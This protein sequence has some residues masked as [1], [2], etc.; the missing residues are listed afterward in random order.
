MT[1]IAAFLGFAFLVD[2]PDR[3]VNKKYWGFVNSEE[4]KFVIRRID[5][6]RSDAGDEPWNFRKW[7]ASAKDWKI[8]TFAMIFLWV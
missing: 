3:A 4:I 2:F 1:V 6:D 7:A 8:W 5:K